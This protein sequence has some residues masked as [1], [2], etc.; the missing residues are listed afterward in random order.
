[1]TAETTAGSSVT[2][3]VRGRVVRPATVTCSWCSTDVMVP[4][5]GR[6]PKWCGT[7][8]RHRAWEQTRAAASG[9]SAVDVVE[10]GRRAGRHRAATRTAITA[11]PDGT[12]GAGAVCADGERLGAAA[13]RTRPA[14]GHRPH[15]HPRPQRHPAHVR[16]GAASAQPTADAL[17]LSGHPSCL[18]SGEVE[19]PPD[20]RRGT[21]DRAFR[22]LEEAAGNKRGSY[23]EHNPTRRLRP[24]FTVSAVSRQIALVVHHQARVSAVFCSTG[25]QRRRTP[26]YFFRRRSTSKTPV[27]TTAT[28][29]TPKRIGL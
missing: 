29:T 24:P 13:D 28:S 7:S 17:T 16:P 12:A 23:Q 11:N 9:R 20:G 5:K 19:P 8:C 25:S 21:T 1:M 14:T 10:R 15:L 27:I 6:V 18:L 3:G 26:P 4:V 22:R 2:S